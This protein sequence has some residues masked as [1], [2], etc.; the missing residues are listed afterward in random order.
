VALIAGH[1]DSAKAGPGALHDLKAVPIGAVVEIVS[2]DGAVSSWTVSGPPE[3]ALKTEL[4][5]SLWVTTGPPKLALVTCGGPFDSAAGHYRD[6]VIVWA[7]PDARRDK[8]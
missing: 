2:A 8:T 3:T 6:N 5:A 7:V 1:V 4:P